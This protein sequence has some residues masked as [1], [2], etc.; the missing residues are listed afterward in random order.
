MFVWLLLFFVFVMLC[1]HS[2]TEEWPMAKHLELKHINQS[3][4]RSI[5]QSN[6]QSIKQT[7]NQSINQFYVLVKKP[8]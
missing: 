3:I 4:D 2:N 7:I 8:Y 6:N 1:I 5:N